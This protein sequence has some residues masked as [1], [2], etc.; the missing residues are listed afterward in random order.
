[1]CNS[2]WF[3]EQDVLALKVVVEDDLSESHAR[4]S[5]KSVKFISFFYF[6]I[7]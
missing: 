5:Q 4:F 3:Y 1:M 2:M 6:T 7:V